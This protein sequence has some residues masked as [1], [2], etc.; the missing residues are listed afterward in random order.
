MSGFPGS[1]SSIVHD[2]SPTTTYRQEAGYQHR[3]SP[4]YSRSDGQTIS[5]SNDHHHISEF[6]HQTESASVA[7]PSM[8]SLTT[9]LSVAPSSSASTYRPTLADAINELTLSDFTTGGADIFGDLPIIPSSVT[10]HQSGLTVPQT[11]RSITRATLHSSNRG[12]YT[13]HFFP[14]QIPVRVYFLNR[15]F[16]RRKGVIG[17]IMRW[18]IRIEE[19]YRGS[20]SEYGISLTPGYHMS[21]DMGNPL[22]L[23]G[24]QVNGEGIFFT[25]PVRHSPAWQE[26]NVR[27]AG[28][29]NQALAPCY[30]PLAISRPPRVGG[31][32]HPHCY[33]VPGHI[34]TCKRSQKAHYLVLH[35]LK[36]DGAVLCQ[37]HAAALYHGP[38]ASHFSRGGNIAMKGFATEGELLSS[39]RLI[40]PTVVKIPALVPY[41]L[42]QLKC[43]DMVEE[44]D[45]NGIIHDPVRIDGT[46]IGRNCPRLFGYNPESQEETIWQTPSDTAIAP[47]Q[48][49]SVDLSRAA[50]P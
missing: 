16:R 4:I 30:L 10:S 37:S 19:A 34:D 12:I 45:T 43:L 50:E 3:E 28:D 33:G 42:E 40:T 15:K 22:C 39:A 29:A 18:R 25:F 41:I 47:S 27:D 6:L 20:F 48:I 11:S 36:G 13:R 8:L 9:P 35:T 49:I 24:Q 21:E 44:S 26:Q 5:H 31:F 14:P 1:Q 38:P 23:V 32:L 17:A 46:H 2:D 7:S